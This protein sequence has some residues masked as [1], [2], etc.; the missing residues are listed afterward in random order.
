MRPPLKALAAALLITFSAPAFADKV[1]DAIASG[2]KYYDD[3]RLSK[4]VR[5]LRYAIAQIS[6]RLSEAYEATMPPAPSGWKTRKARRRGGA[7]G[8]F[9]SA[10]T[11]ITRHYRQEDGRGRITAQLIVDNPMMQAFA[12]MFANPQIAAASGFDRVTVRGARADALLKFD[13]DTK[14]GEAIL[15]LAGRIFI[16]LD[17]R[18]IES[19]GVI[20]DLLQS[21]N[22]EEL[23]KVAEI[24]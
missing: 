9:F 8:G 13:P 16:K 23:K 21:W 6:R 10:G 2:Q 11:I 19:D 14:R 15:L 7:G 12:A 17:G 20:R 24:R 18:R 3:Q 22:Y 4:A 1:T 5:E